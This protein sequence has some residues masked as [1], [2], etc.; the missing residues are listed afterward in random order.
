MIINRDKPEPLGG[1]KCDW[2]KRQEPTKVV[3]AREH[4]VEFQDRNWQ[5]V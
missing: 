2:K 3:S 5:L 4:R 1:F